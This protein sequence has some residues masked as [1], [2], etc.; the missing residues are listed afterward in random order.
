MNSVRIILIVAIFSIFLGSNAFSAGENGRFICGGAAET[1]IWSLWDS[2]VKEYIIRKQVQERLLKQKDVYALYDIQTYAHNMVSMASRCKRIERLT[3]VAD[4]I[5]IAYSALESAPDES[6]GRRWVCRGGSICN[7][8]NRLINT[9]VMLCS[10]QFLGLASSVANALAK[11]GVSL[12]EKQKTFIQDTAQILFEHFLRWGGDSTIAAMQKSLSAKPED[13]KD[14]SSSLFFT[15]K[16]LWLIT[17]YAELAG[18]LESR[19]RNGLNI[20]LPDR[21][22]QERLKKHFAT[23]MEFFLSRISYRYIFDNENGEIKLADIDRGFWRLYSDNRYAGYEGSDKPAVCMPDETNPKKKRVQVQIDAKNVP[24][25]DDTG[26]DISHARRLVHA[27]DALERNSL[28]IRKIFLD[29]FKMLPSDITRAFAN[30]LVYVM[31]NGDSKYPLFSNYLSGANGWYRVAYDIGT[32]DCREGTPPYGLTHSFPTGGY[33]TWAKYNTTIGSLG[34]RLYELANS[35]DE[36]DVKFL[37]RY[38][39][40]LRKDEK[41]QSAILTK[42]MFL[43]T[44]VTKD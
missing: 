4:I 35:T 38:Y 17:I 16:P 18:I 15:D 39:A 25:R 2:N 42:Y 7:D 26:W 34:R 40:G 28:A 24:K 9:E 8:K 36:V 23:L 21:A 37:S 11:S 6:T 27:L 31:W 22:Q 29:V 33:I 19:E 10:V 30:T 1:E 14:G 43:P 32:G 20:V 13:V 41:S 5:S 12:N 3:E 44:L